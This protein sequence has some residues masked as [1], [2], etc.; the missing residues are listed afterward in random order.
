MI[1]L[2]F[3]QS[4]E[5]DLLPGR[6]ISQQRGLLAVITE[7]GLL[8]A[9]TAGR[10]LH[11]SDP[12]ERPAIGDWVACQPRL[13]EQRATIHAVMPRMTCFV[14]K[15]V[16]RRLQVQVIA[17]NIDVAFLVMTMG[18]D[19]NLSRLERYL[20]LT[21]ESGARPVV[22]LTKADLCDDI[23]PIVASVRTC[24][25]SIDL[26]V[27]SALEGKGL[28]EIASYLT[29]QRTG[30]MLGTSGAG[31]STLLNALMETEHA[32]TGPVSAHGG[33]GRH[34][35]THR[36]LVCL[37]SGGLLIDTPGMRELGMVNARESL[38]A[39]FADL[40]A[41]I[42]VLAQQCRFRNCQ[43]EVE[44]GCAVRTACEDG[45]FDERRW[46]NWIKLKHEIAHQQQKKDSAGKRTSRR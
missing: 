4:S 15:E 31:K 9:D 20:T 38:F 34:T 11:T 5:S 10:L 46:N 35:T 28:Q 16:G 17:A 42:E 8:Q 43:H 33:Q 24:A 18:K 21:T 40:T 27:V 45:R 26:Q 19:F 41:E 14:R 7:K 6:V 30:V 32:A 12:L 22:V 13:D 25:P 37:P 3:Q 1:A 44:P 29:G 39:A 36:E 23:E 2:S